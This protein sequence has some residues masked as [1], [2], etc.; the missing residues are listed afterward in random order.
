MRNEPKKDV[1]AVLSSVR[2]DLIKDTVELQNGKCW[3]HRFLQFDSYKRPRFRARQRLPQI[4]TA[5]FS[6]FVSRMQTS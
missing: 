3:I 2:R 4:F 5:L 6:S 1:E